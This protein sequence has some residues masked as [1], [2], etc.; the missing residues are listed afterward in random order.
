[1]NAPPK[2]GTGEGLP[3]GFRWRS[4][5]CLHTEDGLIYELEVTG[6]KRYC[7]AGVNWEGAVLAILDSIAR[8]G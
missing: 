5:H 6:P 8:R 7:R 1:M 3:E 2:L 4:Y